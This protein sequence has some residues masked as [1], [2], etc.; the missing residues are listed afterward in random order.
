MGRGRRQRA[1]PGRAPIGWKILN[2]MDLFQG[3]RHQE[4]NQ[5]PMQIRRNQVIRG[6]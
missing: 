3:T 4:V 2:K 6:R 5:E 1:G